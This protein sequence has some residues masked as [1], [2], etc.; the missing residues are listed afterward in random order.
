MA[1]KCLFFNYVRALCMNAYN[2]GPNSFATTHELDSIAYPYMHTY[3]HTFR[4]C[5]Q[6]HLKANK[7]PNYTY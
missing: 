6:A 4:V 1:Q 2:F 5:G 3:V 7:G